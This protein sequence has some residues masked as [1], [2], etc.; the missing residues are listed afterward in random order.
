MSKFTIKFVDVWDSYE[1]TN[2]MI[3]QLDMGKQD[4]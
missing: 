1:S 3:Y 2:S 4:D